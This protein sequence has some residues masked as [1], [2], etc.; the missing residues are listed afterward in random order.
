MTARLLSG[1]VMAG[2]IVA[3]LLYTPWWVMG[4][5][6][7]AALFVGADE[8]MGMARPDATAC[9][10]AVFL[11][12]NLLVLAWPVAE[13]H[14]P[15]YQHG[16]ALM[17]GFVALAIGRLAR[18]LPIEA[19]LSRLGADAVGLLYIGVTF[20][21]IFQL[22]NFEYGG[23]VLVMVMAITFMSDTGGYFAGRFLGKHKLY[24][25]VSPKKTIEGA[26]GGI[27]AATAAAFAARALFPGHDRLDVLDCVV[28]GVGG[29]VFAIIGDLVESLMKRAYGVKDSGSLIPGHGG[30]LD[31][32]DGLLFAG[33]F[34]WFYL[35]ATGLW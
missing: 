9:D 26:I 32:I 4:L 12:A 16:P 6:V 35:R 10:K 1:V 11:F 30:A 19:A 2:G 3:V 29:A 33:P 31:R 34:C 5:V 25:S 27:A 18:P 14:F 17:L 20:P 22:R 13:P 15:V 28:L 24:P 7:L 8:Y 23:W 21:Y